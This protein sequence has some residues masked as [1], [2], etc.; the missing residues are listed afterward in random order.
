[1]AGFAGIKIDRP[2]EFREAARLGSFS[3]VEDGF[4]EIARRRSYAHPSPPRRALSSIHKAKGLQCDHAMIMACDSYQ[5]S[6]TP[7]SRC[8]LYV[9]L[10]R[11]R[12]SLT[13]VVPDI[14]PTPLLRL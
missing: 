8:K 9:A 7:Y 3:D 13:L 11:A 5:F 1:M 6:S 14:N 10:S 4:A 2:T 12:T